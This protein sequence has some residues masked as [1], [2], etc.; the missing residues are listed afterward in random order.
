MPGM[1]F[2]YLNAS[3][4]QILEEQSKNSAYVGV[5]M[6]KTEKQHIFCKACGCYYGESSELVVHGC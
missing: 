3:N 4:F 6:N 2:C 5:N 1:P